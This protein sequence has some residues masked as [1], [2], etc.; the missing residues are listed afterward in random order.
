[1]LIFVC[2]PP[3]WW[4]DLGVMP[5]NLERADRKKLQLTTTARRCCENKCSYTAATA[6]DKRS[7]TNK[8]ELELEVYSEGFVFVAENHC[9]SKYINDTTMAV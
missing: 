4:S 7:G 3:R 6:E 2:Y 8:K 1:M 5:L 9:Y